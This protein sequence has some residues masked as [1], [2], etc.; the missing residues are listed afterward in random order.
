MFSSIKGQVDKYTQRLNEISNLAKAIK[1]KLIDGSIKGF[2]EQ[3]QYQKIEYSFKGTVIGV[4][5]GFFE[6]S[7]TGLDFCY[8]K[9]AGSFFVYD[10]KLCRY[11]KLL[12]N[13]NYE[14]KTSEN[15]LQKEELPKYVSIS[16]LRQEL[17]LL[18]C[19][20]QNKNP[21]YAL[22]DGNVLPQAV[23][24]PQNNS[25]LYKDYEDLLQDFVKIYDY[26]NS[27]NI[28]LLGCVEDSRAN[29]FLKLAQNDFAS[30]SLLNNINDV[31]FLNYILEKDSCISFF[32]IF[33]TESNLIYNDLQQY[34]KFNF[35]ASYIK[36]NEDYPLRLEL[37]QNNY[38]SQK[39]RDIKG[40]IAHI[41][42]YAKDY[43][44]P[45][46]LLDADEQAKLTQN[47]VNIVK[48]LVDSAILSH[49]IKHLRRERRI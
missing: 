42:N 27:N 18:F 4:D 26:C 2:V 44:F 28:S 35:Y 1:S 46:V 40:F 32:P 29:S 37:L 10:K 6:S 30:K 8:I 31:I 14:F 17:A 47:E 48:N 20:L 21:E 15:S 19:G 25:V 11:E 13:P 5:S 24:R 43:C 33:A 36:V 22:I 49:G 12:Q 7:L 3:E 23:D 41:S 45:S 39:L 16:R 34:G 38:S 9:T